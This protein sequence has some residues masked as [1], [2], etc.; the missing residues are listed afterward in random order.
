MS[1]SICFT[2]II[3]AGAQSI[4]VVVEVSTRRRL[5]TTPLRGSR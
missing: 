3:F 1:P 5:R 2:K 4:G